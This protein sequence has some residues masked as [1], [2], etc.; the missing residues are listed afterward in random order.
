MTASVNKPLCIIPARGNSKRFYRKNVAL[1][2]GKPLLAWTI[3]A[4]S[5]SGIFDHL[6]VSSE[7]DEILETA[8]R[9]GAD[10]VRRPSSLAQDEVTVQELCLHVAKE[11]MAIPGSNYTAIN[12]LLPTSPL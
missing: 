4:A 12:V 8:G 10:P 6:W 7:D 2:G 9:W 5:K 1:L 3:E 11:T